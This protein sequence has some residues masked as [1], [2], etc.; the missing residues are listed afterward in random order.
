[1]TLDE[2]IA[3]LREL[4]EPVPQTL[5]LPTEQ[6]IAEAERRLG[7]RFHP[8]YR[9]FLREAS[10]VTFG[11]KEPATL[12]DPDSHT[13]LTTLAEDAWVQCGVPR[14]LLPICEDNGDYYCMD[15]KGRIVF[16]S[17]DGETEDNWPNLA[18]WIEQVWIGEG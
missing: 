13:E 16:W 4:D 3:Q 5:R 6:E 2:A 14:E 10:N 8:D 15:S 7:I 12:T 18:A 1:M 9:K 17:S 11:T